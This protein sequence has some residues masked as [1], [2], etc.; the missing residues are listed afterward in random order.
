MW[1]D[2]GEKDKAREGVHVCWVNLWLS[3]SGKRRE[4]GSLIIKSHAGMRQKDRG[5]RV[6]V[7][8]GQW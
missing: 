6:V 1:Q 2:G 7:N 4:E 8:K 5:G 3:D